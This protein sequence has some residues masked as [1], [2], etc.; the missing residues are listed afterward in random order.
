MVDTGF[1]YDKAAVLWCVITD[2]LCTL[3]IIK[4]SMDD[5]C[6][7]YSSRIVR[8]INSRMVRWIGTCDTWGRREMFTGLLFEN[9][10]ERDT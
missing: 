4:Y 5:H 1:L 6:D 9:L 7:L 8:V 10:K 3:C 2:A